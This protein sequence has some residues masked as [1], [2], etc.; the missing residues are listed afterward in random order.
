MSKL[1]QLKHDLKLY[2]KLKCNGKKIGLTKGEI[3][4]FWSP[5]WNER[6]TNSKNASWLSTL[7]LKYCRGTISKNYIIDSNEF[8]KF[9]SKMKNN[10]V[11]SNNLIPYWIKN[12]NIVHHFYLTLEYNG[13][14]VDWLVMGRTILLLKKNKTTLGKKP[15]PNSMLEHRIQTVHWN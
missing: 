7:E 14:P 12:I 1:T 2:S 13:T 3:E 4:L 5:L 6:I 15:T 11:P 9:L 10:G 8:D